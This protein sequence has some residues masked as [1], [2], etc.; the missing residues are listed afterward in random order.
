[1]LGCGREESLTMSRGHFSAPTFL[2]ES[3]LIRVST[4]PP[5]QNYCGNKN[6]DLHVTTLLVM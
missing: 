1:M 6:L 3:T 5:Q 4:P 2:L